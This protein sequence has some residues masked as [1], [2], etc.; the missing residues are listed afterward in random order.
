LSK[1][2]VIFHGIVGGILGRN[3]MGAPIDLEVCAKTINKNI[4]SAGECDVF[5]HSWSKEHKASILS[6]YTP[7]KYLFQE[8]EM[9]GYFLNGDSLNNEDKTHAFRTVSRYT[10]LERA[11]NLK[12]EYE[13][14]NNFKY[15]WVLVLRFD[16]VFFSK[17]VLESLNKNYF[18][19]CQ[20]PHWP[21]LSAHGGVLHDIFFLANSN[22]LDEFSNIASEIRTGQYTHKLHA[23]H[24]VAYEKI[25]KMFGSKNNLQYLFKRYVDVEI[26]RFIMKPELNPVG[27]AYGALDMKTRLHNYMEVLK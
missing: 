18:Y 5:I 19:I 26:Y 7:K 21:D 4:L 3:G 1:L 6:L 23:A 27:H 24:T 2:A 8:Q 14:E 11:M 22:I 25:I 10:S 13:I 20:E 12:K 15:D 9:L 17:L 16:L